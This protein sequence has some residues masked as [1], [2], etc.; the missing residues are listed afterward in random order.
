MTVEMQFRTSGG[1]LQWLRE[2]KIGRE[3]P[4]LGMA[5]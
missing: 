4:N 5:S 3:V 2:G 1:G